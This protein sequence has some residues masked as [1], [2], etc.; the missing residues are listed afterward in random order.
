M[1]NRN[2]VLLR[3]W[4]RRDFLSRAGY[5]AAG[6]SLASI[7]AA[8]SSDSSSAPSPQS[9]G[10]IAGQLDFY[11]WQGYDLP[12]AA[13]SWLEEHDVQLKAG[14]ISTNEDMPTK[15]LSA[16]GA[17]ID[18]ITYA[19]YFSELDRGLGVVTDIQADEIPELTQFY[20]AFRSGSNWRT[21]EGVYT[22]IP[23]SWGSSP[24]TYNPELV[25]AVPTSWMDL[26]QPEF[27]G[28]IAFMDDPVGGITTAARILGFPNIGQLSPSDLDQVKG[29]LLK[30]KA[31]AKVIAATYGDL[32]NLFDSGEIVASF[33]GWSA[34]TV[35]AA[36]AKLVPAYPSEGV[37]LYCDSFA[38]P[39]T[40]DNRATALG[41]IN[42]VSTKEIQ[43]A[44]ADYLA[45]GVVRPDAIPL[46]KN[47]LVRQK[48]YPYDEIEP[49]F[50][51]SFGYSIATKATD[52]VVSYD[53]WLSMWESVKA[54]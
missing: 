8:C 26:L 5:A 30:M 36:H 15:V 14:Y 7:L 22:G 24:L 4:S 11:S 43:A 45:G 13:K 6:L 41:W 25:P 2:S 39:P 19:Q 18:L 44:A 47:G 1:E 46:I 34:L 29:L 31:Q 48:L 20:D 33:V 21:S 28:K 51:S 12:D 10:K 53:D 50:A 9:S 42:L 27:K 3:K 38:I 40:T 23:F 54:A 35:F 32:T 49:L 52:Q 16:A 37:V 17:G